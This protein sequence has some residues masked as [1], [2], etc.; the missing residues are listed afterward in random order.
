M[1]SYTRAPGP[2]SF[3]F[4]TDSGWIRRSPAPV[5]DAA[6]SDEPGW[7]RAHTVHK[8]SKLKVSDPGQ[9]VALLSERTLVSTG[10]LNVRSKC[11]RTRPETR[12]TR[13]SV[14]RNLNRNV[15]GEFIDNARAW[16]FCGLPA[17]FPAGLRS[18]GQAAGHGGRKVEPP[19]PK[20]NQLLCRLHLGF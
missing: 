1:A 9:S 12:V 16:V 13:H 20:R 7:S 3:D 2:E 15:A 19:G 14:Y 17:S 5:C 8:G 6:L 4:R 11:P 18:F 10:A